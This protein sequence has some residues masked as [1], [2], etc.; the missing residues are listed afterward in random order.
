MKKLF[1]ICLMALLFVMFG[2]MQFKRGVIGDMYYSETRPNIRLKID[3]SLRYLGEVKHSQGR[4][5]NEAYVW[6]AMGESG[7]SIDKMFIVEHSTV[8]QERAKLT[9]SDL[10]RGLPHFKKGKTMIGE[11]SFQYV[12]FIT[13]PQGKNFWTDFI[14][15]KGFVLNKPKL[16]ACYGKIS[17]DTAWTKFYYMQSYDPSQN[18]REPF[19]QADEAL[20]K[21][22]IANFKNDIKYR[23]KYK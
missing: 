17:T 16:T 7:P 23:G 18:F 22:F 8:S 6:V 19:T 20:F 2:F 10:F 13:E 9:P 5:R 15:Q 1:I 12:M 4:M 14:T 11:E 21:Q 3:K